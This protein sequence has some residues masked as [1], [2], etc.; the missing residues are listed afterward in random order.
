MN[1]TKLF[2]SILG[3]GMLSIG[4]AQSQTDSTKVEQL[5]EVV[6][7][8]SKFR[9]KRE[10]SGKVITKITSKELEKLQGQSIAE[11]VGRA[12]GV[13]INGVR[14]N[15]GQNL[16]Y[17]IRGG[18]NRQVLVL[19]DGIQVTDP[20][21]IA[22]DYDLRM[23][24]ADQVESIE[25]LKGAS[26]TLY[27]TGAATAVIN[28]TL[29]EA[30]KKAFNL[31]LKSSLGTNQSSEEN[32]YAFEDFRNSVSVNGTVG[33]FNYLASFGQQFTD[34]LSA[35]ASGTESDAYNS[36]SGNL[37]L[38]YKFSNAFKL[39][40]YGSF[41]RF[42][43]DFDDGFGMVDADNQS[44]AKQYRF[45]VSPEFIYNN[46]SVTVNAAINDVDREI[47]SNFPSIFNSESI[48]IDA[49]NRYNFSDAFYTV[50]GVNFQDNKMESYSIPFGATDLSQSINPDK[51]TFTITDPY[52]N[53]VFVSDFGLNLNV[54]ARLNNHSEY[55][56][57]LVYSLNPSFVKE[58]DFGYIK[59]LASY[60]TA[61][62]APS[63]YQL[64]EP[65]Y[66]NVDL[67]PE[68]NQTIEVGA[69]VSIKDKATLS[70]VYFNRN[71]D[72]FI[73]FVDT[74]GFVFQYK[75]IDES[76]TASGIEFVG[77]AEITKCLNIN[78]NATYTK[79]DE[80]LS[81]R[82][83]EIKINTR[84]DYELTDTT[85]LSLAYQYNDD[86]E[87]SVFNSTTFTND[88]VNL[89]S[90]GLLDVYVSHKVMSNKMT[91]F[92]NITN[93]FNEEYQE[94]FGFST[95]GRGV[96]LGFNLNL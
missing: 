94:L 65:T 77:Q 47:K 90:Y 20:S 76:F 48:V 55:G 44:I 69:E 71:E 70:L 22:N 84:V 25:I 21:Q 26:S 7:T 4:Y 64:F 46:G 91:L 23:L 40:T 60:S 87:D 15:A 5:D 43:A 27:G 75:N 82:I 67:K 34:G 32:N 3:L 14:S 11:I 49:F 6:V 96:N 72:N 33:R 45:G 17:F 68:E 63:L 78:L 37:K 79:L 38:G 81:L 35:I 92:A 85:L 2:C 1:K 89:D 57:H 50:L 74:G 9:L 8:D 88:I 73:D 10:N 59:T 42:K 39:K 18:R 51:A 86:R 28:I 24:N 29:K 30:S 41:D 12:V 36:F 58:T 31:N 16:S 95:K 13:E 53:V 93:I 19:I 56:S 54:G 83:P 66:G 62:I 80:D 61:F 52:A